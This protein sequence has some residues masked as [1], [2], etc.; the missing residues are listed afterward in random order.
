MGF[1]LD[2]GTDCF[3]FFFQTV[4]NLGSHFAFPIATTMCQ[5]DDGAYKNGI[6]ILVRGAVCMYNGLIMNSDSDSLV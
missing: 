4:Y 2:C 6:C 1:E 5:F 3:V